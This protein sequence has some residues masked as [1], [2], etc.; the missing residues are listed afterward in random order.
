MRISDA[1][2]RRARQLSVPW[3]WGLLQRLQNCSILPANLVI[4]FNR[5]IWRWSVRYPEAGVRLRDQLLFVTCKDQAPRLTF[6]ITTR[7]HQPRRVRDRTKG[8]LQ[9]AVNFVF[10][11]LLS[12]EFSLIAP[13]TLR[14][15]NTYLTVTVFSLLIRNLSTALYII[16][17]C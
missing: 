3:C 13:N 8:S 2:S 14:L 10:S 15:S 11:L 9:R 4:L 17:I 1:N 6:R 16:F 7:L 12:L 5:S